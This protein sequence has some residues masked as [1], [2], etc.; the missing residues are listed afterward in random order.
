MEIMRI[1]P[2]Q[3]QTQFLTEYDTAVASA[4]RPEQYRQLHHVLGLWNG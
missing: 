1:L 4:R 3:Y 2:D